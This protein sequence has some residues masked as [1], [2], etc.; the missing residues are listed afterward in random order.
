MLLV[1]VGMFLESNAANIMLVP[2]FVPIAAAFGLD[3]L[4]FGFLFMYNLVVGMMTPPVGVLFFVMSGITGVS[5]SVIVRES[6]PFVVYQFLVLG[7]C[8]V[9]PAAGD[10]AAERAGV[11]RSP[12][13]E[14]SSLP[15]SPCSVP[16]WCTA[17]GRSDIVENA[18]VADPRID[19]STYVGPRR[20]AP[21]VPA[22]LADARSPGTR[23]RFPGS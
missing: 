12:V 19:R 23:R 16:R 21:D 4:W 17:T 9:F 3:P 8:I 22:G 20:G 1:F 2:L 18:V 15:T 14:R 5:M 7:L 10:R 6:M 11:L 13:D